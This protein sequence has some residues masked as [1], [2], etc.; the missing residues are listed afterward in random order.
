MSPRR[1]AWPHEK[2]LPDQ[3][4]AAVGAI[5]IITLVVAATIIILPRLGDAVDQKAQ[6]H[7]AADAAALAAATAGRD[8]LINKLLSDASSSFANNSALVAA[9][10]HATQND[11]D[12]TAFSSRPF[13]GGVQYRVRTR[14]LTPINGSDQRAEAE[15]VAEVSFPEPWCHT[16]LSIGIRDGTT[17]SPASAVDTDGL[18]ANTL[19]VRLIE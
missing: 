18:L 7:S 4:Q 1:P 3:G 17:C 11:A 2:L 9:R 15:A 19:T 14:S 12:I 16:N 5:P 10:R 13:I 6:Q 8:A